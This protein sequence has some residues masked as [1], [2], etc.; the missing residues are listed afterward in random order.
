MKIMQKPRNPLRIEKRR[1]V[2]VKKRLKQNKWESF[3]SVLHGQFGLLLLLLLLLFFESSIIF[4]SMLQG[5]A[6]LLL[7]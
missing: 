1:G 6:P 5:F 2:R 4:F 7:K 3:L